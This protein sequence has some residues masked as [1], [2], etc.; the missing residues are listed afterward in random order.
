MDADVEADRLRAMRKALREGGGDGV[1]AE[2]FNT[3]LPTQ[4]CEDEDWAAGLMQGDWQAKMRGLTQGTSPSS[5]PARET[6]AGVA[7]LSTERADLLRLHP[8]QWRMQ[9]GVLSRV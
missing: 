1:G 4:D 9:V 7:G 6:S 3:S 2:F 8:H 5:H